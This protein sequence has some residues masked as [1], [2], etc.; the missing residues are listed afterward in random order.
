MHSRTSTVC[1]SVCAKATLT[2]RNTKRETFSMGLNLNLT[3]QVC[4]QRQNF[5]T[6]GYCFISRKWLTLKTMLNQPLLSSKQ[7]LTPQNT[8]PLK[9]ISVMILYWSLI[10]PFFSNCLKN[11][12]IPLRSF[13]WLWFLTRSKSL[14]LMCPWDL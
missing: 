6:T 3:W 9:F 7:S 5:T 14:L 13:R 11:N 10:N 1:S 8:Q 12:S 4:R 2:T